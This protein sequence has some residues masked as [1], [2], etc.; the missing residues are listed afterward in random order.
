MNESR[1]DYLI[2]EIA[3]QTKEYFL[4]SNRNCCQK[5][6]RSVVSFFT[7]EVTPHQI[8]TAAAAIAEAIVQ[9]QKQ[10]QSSAIIQ[11]GMLSNS[12][13]GRLSQPVSPSTQTPQ[14]ETGATLS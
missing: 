4:P 1:R 12:Q 8:S 11:M 2:H 10:R 13:S 14:E 7:S 5:S 9:S 6:C 3:A